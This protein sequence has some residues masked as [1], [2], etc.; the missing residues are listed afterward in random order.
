[1]RW[2]LLLLLTVLP[3][4]ASAG[5]RATYT[6]EGQP[7]FVVEI[8]D[9]GDVSA[10]LEQDRRLIVRAGEAF[11]IEERL[12]GPLVTRLS[13]YAVLVRR[14]PVE[15]GAF[16][17][18]FIERGTSEVNGRSGRAFILPARVPQASDEIFAVINADPDLADLAPAMRQAF[19]AE[20]LLMGAGGQVAEAHVA[21]SLALLRV[22]EAGSPLRFGP[23]S[24]RDVQR[25]AIPPD[26]FL[27]PAEPES[28]E[29]LSARLTADRSEDES[30]WEN[31]MISRAVFASDRLWL[32]TDNGALTSLAEGDATRAAHSLGPVLDICARDG[33]PLAITGR[34]DRGREW[35]LHRWQD[36]GWQRER[37][38]PREDDYLVAMSCEGSVAMLL[39]VRRLIDL[40]S[41]ESLN[42][43]R[44]LAPALVR[45]TV[46][47][48]P[49]AVFVG[50]NAGEWGGGM[51]RIDR[52]TGRIDTLERNATGDRCD[53]PL[54][55]QCDPVHGIA[56]V[57]WRPQCMAAAVGLIHMLAHGRITAVC[58]DSIERLFVATDPDSVDPADSRRMAEAAKGSHGSVAFFGL[59]RAGDS[60]IAAGH[61]GLYRIRADGAS[62]QRGPRFTEVDGILVS[63]ALPDVVLVMSELNRRASVSGLAPLLVPR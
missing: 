21:D 3:A 18:P 1:M 22:L 43:S 13:D 63:F 20:I 39:T 57:P 19:L 31:R 55:T 17:A 50:L 48:S 45:T 54:N 32:L 7:P 25:V 40:Q 5:I 41:N 36:G 60:L 44:E 12:T 26:R 37:S 14:S 4:T 9:N 23:Y 51:K 8:A 59:V 49:D 33:V 6:V 56:A 11:V 53:G 27:L 61:N 10:E 34:R 58:P 29:A 30:G 47:V 38:I 28:R 35:V 2:I 24:L 15:A 46:T 16:P 62:H 52:R 42:L